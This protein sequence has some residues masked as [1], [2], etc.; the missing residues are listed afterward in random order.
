MYID[1]SLLPFQLAYVILGVGILCVIQHTR[2]F[3]GCLHTC[4][5]KF[6]LKVLPFTVYQ[7]EWKHYWHVP[8][9]SFICSESWPASCLSTPHRHLPII[10]NNSLGVDLYHNIS[11][12]HVCVYVS[13]CQSLAHSYRIICA[14]S[15]R[16]TRRVAAQSYGVVYAGSTRVPPM[17]S[18]LAMVNPQGT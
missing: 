7:F 3:A 15:K 13:Y 18:V 1:T 5:S 11:K 12:V 16:S 8:Y 14:G 17:I 2:C 4:A 9:I 6:T 10:C